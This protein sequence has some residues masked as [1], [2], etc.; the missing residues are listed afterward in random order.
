[1]PTFVGL[2]CVAGLL[3]VAGLAV[4][5]G[6]LSFGSAVVYGASLSASLVGFI[7]AL[8]HLIAGGWRR[9]R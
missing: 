5:V 9:S 7:V 6:R 3:A 8:M 2:W 4:A 1:M